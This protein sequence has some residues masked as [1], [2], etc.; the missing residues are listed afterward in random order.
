MKLCAQAPLNPEFSLCG[1]AED[2]PETEDDVEPF[3]F[4][5]EGETLTCEACM[6]IIKHV[7]LDYTHRFKRR[8]QY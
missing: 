6:Q 3:R 4:A 2:A 7:R 1:D 5:G 8:K